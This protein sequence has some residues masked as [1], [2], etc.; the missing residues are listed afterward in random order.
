MGLDLKILR[1]KLRKKLPYWINFQNLLFLSV[2]I[3]FVII[4]LWSERISYILNQSV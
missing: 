2:I 4:V 1:E 3:A